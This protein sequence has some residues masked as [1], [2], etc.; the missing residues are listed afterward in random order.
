MAMRAA[1]ALRPVA[2]TSQPQMMVPGMSPAEM[3]MTMDA[4]P[5][6]TSTA[7]L[8]AKSEADELL[9]RAS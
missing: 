1:P 7:M 4:M 5:A 2:L 8:L 3:S 6:M 9:V